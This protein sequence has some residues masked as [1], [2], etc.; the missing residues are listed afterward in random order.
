MQDYSQRKFK[1]AKY[2]KKKVRSSIVRYRD[3][4]PI[5]PEGSYYKLKVIS[6]LTA[7]TA[8]GSGTGQ[9][10]IQATFAD[11][12]SVSA[13]WTSLG[14]LYDSYR[15]THMKL[16]F[17]PLDPNEQMDQGALAG[18]H[19]IYPP[20]AVAYDVDNSSFPTL[21]NSSQY[22]T[23]LQYG[24]SKVFQSNRPWKYQVKCT[25]P[26]AGTS[27]AAVAIIRDGMVDVATSVSFSSIL[28]GSQYVPRIDSA[29]VDWIVGKIVQTFYV[30]CKNRR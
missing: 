22:E 8:T 2:G 9:R 6:D 15:V 1:K 12:P 30:Y 4:L 16:E 17:F 21:V 14:H 18:G 25:K 23:I 7:N 20:I 11:D 3:G 19:G 10:S 26:Y 27:S 29:A 5:V 13:D 28:V 24:N